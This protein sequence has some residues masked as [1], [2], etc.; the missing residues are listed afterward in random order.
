MD[1]KEM[2]KKAESTY[3]KTCAVCNEIE[4]GLAICERLDSDHILIER[5]Q[6]EYNKVME[7]RRQ[8]Y[9]DLLDILAMLKPMEED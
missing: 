2:F 9:D 8:A 7:L 6:R 5:Y 4:L 1:L 3:L